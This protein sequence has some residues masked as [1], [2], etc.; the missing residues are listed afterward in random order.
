MRKKIISKTILFLGIMLF[1][2]GFQSIFGNKNTVVG[3]TVITAALSLLERDLTISPLENLMKLI[4]INLFTGLVAF[5]SSNNM[6]MGVILNFIAVFLIGYLFSYELRKSIVVPFVLQYLFMLYTPVYGDFFIKRILALIFGAFFIMGLQVIVNKDKVYNSGKKILYELIENILLKLSLLKKGEEVS[7]INLDIHESANTLKKIIYDKRFK[8]F[9][10]T[11]NGKTII[12]TLHSLER[13]NIL[14]DNISGNKETDRYIKALNYIY[15][16]LKNFKDKNSDVTDLILVEE[17]WPEGNLNSIYVHEINKLINSLKNDL[18]KIEKLNKKDKNVVEYKFAI[19]NHFN[20]ITIHKRNFKIDSIRVSYG[21]RV[22]ILVS[23][24]GFITQYFNL[25]E[26][27]WMAYTIFSVI[28]PYSENCKIK[29][30][31][32]LEGTLIGVAIIFILFS[33]IHSTTARFIIVLVA[34]YLNPFTT[35]YRDLIICVTVSAIASVAL[36]DGIIKFILARLIFVGIGVILALVANRYI[37]PY[38]IENGKRDLVKTSKSLVKQMLLDINDNEGEHSVKNLYLISALIEE[39]MKL[40]KFGQECSK[41]REFMHNQKILVISI[42]NYHLL[43][44][45]NESSRVNIINIIEEIKTLTKDNINYLDIEKKMKKYISLL[46]EKNE[47]LLLKNILDI[48]YNF[49]ITDSFS[50]NS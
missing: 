20:K 46:E 41:E 28:Q 18:C 35:N 50:I 42:Y 16:N 3:V 4:G 23:V 11:N 37:F 1:I 36:L 45:S 30:K 15:I 43:V 29:S 38:K 10:I 17:I 7:N 19:P 9:Y 24:T 12:N 8:D 2:N 47:K 6:C 14:I 25:S 27:R 31:Q 40:I 33:L 39:K 44:K 34:G 21:I 49:D 32:R 5:W 13:I 48:I 26:G 22:G